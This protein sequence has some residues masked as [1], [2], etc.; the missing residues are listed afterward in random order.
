MITKRL[1]IAAM[2]AAL[3]VILQGC[4]WLALPYL[5]RTRHIVRD[6]DT[7][8]KLAVTYYGS[9]TKVSLLMD[10]NPGLTPIEPLSP[11][12]RVEIPVD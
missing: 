10:A 4:S 6:G 9:E 7:L 11:G 3:T 1:H 2:L 5:S 12:S 8:N